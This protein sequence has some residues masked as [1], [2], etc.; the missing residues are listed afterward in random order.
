MKEESQK[1]PTNVQESTSVATEETSSALPITEL[2][3]QIDNLQTEA[4]EHR[5]KFLRAVADLDNYRKRATRDREELVRVAT[6]N[7][8]EDLLPILD[9]FKLG[10][11]SAEQAPE[12]KQHIQGFHMIYDQLSQLLE[13]K[14]LEAINPDQT[15]FDPTLH[16]CIA[17]QPSDSVPE[18]RIMQVVRIGYKLNGKL[19]RP[20]SV[21]VSSGPEEKTSESPKVSS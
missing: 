3:A 15:T 6:M 10:L 8:V 2:L 5:E 19:L 7:L 16:E 12:I 18:D 20:A 4:N 1:D 13:G 11:G 14:G 17:H 9:N 21:I